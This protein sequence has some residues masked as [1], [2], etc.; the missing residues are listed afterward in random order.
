M[1]SSWSLA[2]L[3]GRFLKPILQR[4]ARFSHWEQACA[5]TAAC[6][7]LLPLS[8]HKCSFAFLSNGIIY[9]PSNL[10]P[11]KGNPATPTFSTQPIQNRI[12]AC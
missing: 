11:T 9:N 10:Y 1:G 12:C 6:L 8:L 4:I 2:T 5:D 7:S 3:D